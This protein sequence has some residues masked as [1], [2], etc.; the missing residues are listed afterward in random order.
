MVSHLNTILTAC[1][2]CCMSGATYLE[3]KHNLLTNENIFG[4]KECLEYVVM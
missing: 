2:V 3:L 1:F 4:G